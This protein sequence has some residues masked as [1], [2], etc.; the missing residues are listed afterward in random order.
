MS[1]LH[2]YLSNNQFDLHKTV[3][4]GHKHVPFE[5]VVVK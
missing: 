2:L 1:F 3:I 5:E 4:G